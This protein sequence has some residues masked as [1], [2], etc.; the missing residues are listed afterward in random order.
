LSYGSIS[1]TAHFFP[2]WITGCLVISWWWPR[3][4]FVQC[5]KS[6][7]MHLCVVFHELGLV[8]WSEKIYTHTWFTKKFMLH[9]DFSQK[10]SHIFQSQ[11]T[12]NYQL[13]N[14]RT[15]S[16]FKKIFLNLSIYIYIYIYTLSSYWIRF[17][18]FYFLHFQDNKCFYLFIYV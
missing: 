10:K 9:E 13:R 18:I 15:R 17:F 8:L 6:I 2:M 4:Q 16:F 12:I 11:M 14:N 7:Y 1:S 3:I 5:G